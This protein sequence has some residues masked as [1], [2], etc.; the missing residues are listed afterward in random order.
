MQDENDETPTFSMPRFNATISEDVPSGFFVTN[1]TA[2]DDD[3]EEFGTLTYSIG[4]VFPNRSE[5]FVIEPGTGVVRTS[6]MFDRESSP[7][8]YL[9]TVRQ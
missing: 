9:V 8:P 2:R 1:M 7:G 3:S 6:G 4:G 5:T